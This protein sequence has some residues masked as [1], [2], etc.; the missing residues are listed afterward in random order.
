[1]SPVC[2]TVTKEEVALPI[3]LLRHFNLRWGCVWK[4]LESCGSY[5]MNKKD[6][7]DS[8]SAR[9]NILSFASITS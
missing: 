8:G 6:D 9:I 3:V 7:D 5:D 1:M 2:F 4:L